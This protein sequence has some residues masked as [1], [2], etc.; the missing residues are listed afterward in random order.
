MRKYLFSISAI[1]WTIFITIIS[2]ISLKDA[3]KIGISFADKLVHGFVYFLFTI[4]WFFAFSKGF[5]TTFLKKNALVLSAIFAIIYGICIEIMQATL[6]E[7]RQGDLED[8]IANTLG[9]I[10][11]VIVLKW[12]IAN[13]RKLKTQN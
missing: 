4:V 1:A 8:V 2:L 3:P 6:V 5:A 13:N 10:L 7:N 12:L 11:A 9:T